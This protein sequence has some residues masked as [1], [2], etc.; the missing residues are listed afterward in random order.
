M[1]AMIACPLTP[2]TSL[3]VLASWIFI[4]V[5][6]FCM[7]CTARP[8]SLTCPVPHPPDGPHRFHV[9]LQPERIAH[10]S[11][12]VQFHQPLAFLHVGLASGYILGVLRVH[13]RHAD[14]ML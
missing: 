14:A 12:G 1:A 11:V 4:L 2:L 5:I 6:A 9:L 10:Q 13:Q 8:A 3:M 7:C